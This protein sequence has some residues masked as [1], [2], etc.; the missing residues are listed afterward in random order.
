MM[1]LAQKGWHP[2]LGRLKK[3]E[4]EKWQFKNTHTEKHLEVGRACKAL[5]KNGANI[6]APGI[7]QIHRTA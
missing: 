3:S 1:H 2:P 7:C 6:S 5:A 4:D